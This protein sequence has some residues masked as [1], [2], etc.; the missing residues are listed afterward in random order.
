MIFESYSQKDTEDFAAKLARDA[1]PGSVYALMGD[2]GAGKTAF[3]RGFAR[4]LGV[5]ARVSSPT[6]AIVNEY[7]GSFLPFYHFDVYRIERPEDMEDTG[8]EEYFYGCGVVLV[9]WADLIEELLPAGAVRISLER[10]DAHGEDYR[11]IRLA[12]PVETG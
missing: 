10:D 3:G 8:Y 4:G 7:D 6:F 1:K 11:R 2:L 9:E 5:T 12:M